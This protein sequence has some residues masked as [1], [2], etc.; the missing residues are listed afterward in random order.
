MV[1]PLP[2][3][4]PA[5]DAWRFPPPPV[6]G[7]WLWVAIGAGA[8]EIVFGEVVTERKA[9]AQAVVEALLPQRHDGA[10]FEGLEAAAIEILAA[11]EGGV[12][13]V[14]GAAEA[15]G[16]RVDEFGGLG[17]GSAGQQGGEER[18]AELGGSHAG[19]PTPGRSGQ[20]Q[21]AVRCEDSG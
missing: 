10:Q 8:A 12:D 17:G 20:T 21:K 15:E 14:A 7:R 11:D 5:H 6:S 3:Y 19:K 16:G 13:H 1:D 2:P 4:P 9:E 18:A